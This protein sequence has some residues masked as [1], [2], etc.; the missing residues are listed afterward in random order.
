M[1]NISYG[2]IHYMDYTDYSMDEITG[3]FA[4]G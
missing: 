2:I 4:S 3:G 1:D